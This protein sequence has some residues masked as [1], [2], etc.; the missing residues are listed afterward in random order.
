MRRGNGFALLW[1]GFSC[2]LVLLCFGMLVEADISCSF[3]QP[4]GKWRA[5]QL[6]LKLDAPLTA[7]GEVRARGQGFSAEHDCATQPET[8]CLTLPRRKRNTRAQEFPETARDNRKSSFTREEAPNEARTHRARAVASRQKRGARRDAP[9]SRDD[10]KT[11][12][13]RGERS[14]RWSKDELQLT[15]STFALSGDS[16]HNQAM[17]HWSGQNS[18]VSLYNFTNPS[19]IQGFPHLSLSSASFHAM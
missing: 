10:P 12:P 4:V 3:C 2:A 16:A 15:S 11:R 13:T 9:G 1:H 14:L 19:R 6:L 18:S 17:V 7:T 5:R 8:P